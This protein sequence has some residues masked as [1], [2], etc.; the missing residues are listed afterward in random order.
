VEK[1]FNW[2]SSQIAYTEFG[3]GNTLLI[4]FHGYGQSGCIFKK[5][6]SA[7]S[8]QYRV[9]SIDL[10]HQGKTQWN[11]NDELTIADLE[12]LVRSLMRH[13][14]ESKDVSLMAFSI[15]GN[16][17]LG[18][19]ATCPDIVNEIW[20]LAAD[21]LYTRRIFYFAT[22]TVIGKRIFHHFIE[23]PKFIFSLMRLMLKTGQLDKKVYKF[24]RGNYDTLEKRRNVYKRWISASRMNYRSTR[25]I[26]LA[27][28]HQFRI[29]LLYGKFDKVI[30]LSRAKHFHKKVPS[31]SL[32]ILEQGH[33][34]IKTKNSKFIQEIIDDYKAQ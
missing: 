2:R 5:F 9:V 7:L 1:E 12:D 8:A 30:P 20:L 33:D 31:S 10:P 34:L 4:A 16:Y 18:L 6:E 25:I 23:H 22:K 13:F 14:N 28:Q 3:S 17:A 32:T 29:H 21:G 24:Y 26:E 19:A 27:N 15:G 11:E